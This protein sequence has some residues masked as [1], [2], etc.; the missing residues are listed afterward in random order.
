MAQLKLTAAEGQILLEVLQ[1]SITDL[2]ME[3]ADTDQKD[4]RDILKE[5]KEVLAK[6]VRELQ[7]PSGE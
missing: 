2:G 3:I 1:V 4:Y 6:I 7:Q 5:R